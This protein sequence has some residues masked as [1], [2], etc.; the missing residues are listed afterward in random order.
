MSG[1]G[2]P[3]KSLADVR[4]TDARSAQICRP[5]GVVRTFQV[6]EYSVEPSEGILARNLLSK[7]RCR[8]ALADEFPE[9]GPEVPFV[10]GSPTFSGDGERLAGAASGPHRAINW[11]SREGKC[12]RPPTD[13]GEKVALGIGGE[14]MGSNIRD[15]SFVHVT[16]R[17]EP[18]L[19]EFPQPRGGLRVVLVVK[20]H[21]AGL[22]VFVWQF[23]ARSSFFNCVRE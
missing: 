15:A 17:D 14:V 11:P 2:H 7:D 22:Q 12:V 6:S 20:I 16:G 13:P 18:G 8:S 1:V 23:H 19:D 9:N 10:G 5:A 3:V 4:R 21:R